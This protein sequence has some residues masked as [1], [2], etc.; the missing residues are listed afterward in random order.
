MTGLCAHARDPSIPA[1]AGEPELAPLEPSEVVELVVQHLLAPGQG[2]P[3]SA[4]LEFARWK[5][6]VS[7]CAV[8]RLQFA[9]GPAACVCVKRY[10]GRKAELLAG[11]A[12]ADERLAELAAP[13]LPAALLPERGLHLWAPPADRELRGWP[14]LLDRGR[15]KRWL[16]P[17]LAHR[18][19][20]LSRRGIAAEIV[21]FK[22]ERRA[23][24]KLQLAF[25]RE[26]RTER[27][28]RLLGARLLPPAEAERVARAR[29]ACAPSGP[30]LD[31]PELVAADVAAGIVIEDWLD[32]AP[33]EEPGVDA[34]EPG[35]SER[36][37][38]AGRLAAL[39]H[40][41]E[42]PRDAPP[43]PAG[44]QDRD[45]LGDQGL[46]RA[47]DPRSGTL[48]RLQHLRRGLAEHAGRPAAACW[49]H[50]DLH[51]DQVARRTLESGAAGGQWA[52]LDLDSLGAGDP[53]SDLASWLADEVARVGDPGIASAGA[54]RDA[55]LAGYARA[56]GRL[57]EPAALAPAIA[58]ALVRRAA[59]GLRRLERGAGERAAELLAL[60]EDL[61]PE[62]VGR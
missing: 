29:R 13:L 20:R 17:L 50:G 41:R 2:A 4:E 51:A 35:R 10:R 3:H 45:L 31:V 15:T 60:A 28:A 9:G 23:V 25:D 19:E 37:E 12:Q 6:G 61:L 39:L 62:R 24:A 32:L 8:Y 56:G 11:R 14:R 53:A 54:E 46:W 1:R 43:S 44:C 5:P 42:L 36:A 59:G 40:R 52:L 57:P 58:L 22:P 34:L 55:L 27:R 16:G 38:A 18:G 21:R 49:I 48:E 26:G 30:P 33:R 7:L 47:V